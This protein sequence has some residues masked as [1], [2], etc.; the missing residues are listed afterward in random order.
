MS[1]SVFKKRKGEARF[2]Y[3]SNCEVITVATGGF[4]NGA[5]VEI[6]LFL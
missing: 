2:M 3:P 1:Q 4:I 6:V 5:V